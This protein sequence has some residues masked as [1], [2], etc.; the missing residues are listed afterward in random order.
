M[1]L[2]P[3][4]VRRLTSDEG[5]ERR[6]VALHRHL[7]AEPVENGWHDVYV[8]GKGIDL[9]APTSLRR[10]LGVADDE[11][12]VKGFVE[13]PALALQ[14]VIAEVLTMIGSEDDEG[15]VVLAGALQLIDDASD[16][17]V[18]LAHQ[19]IVGGSGLEDGEVVNVRFPAVVVE[20]IRSAPMVL[21]HQGE[22]RVLSG[23]V[24]GGR[25][26]A[27]GGN[28]ARVVHL[29]IR[30]RRHE[31]RVW[32]LERKVEEPGAFAVDGEPVE[33]FAGG[34]G[35]FAL[36]GAVSRRR[37]GV[38][39]LLGARV[40]RDLFIGIR[41]ALEPL[42]SP[43]FKPS[44]PRGGVI[45]DLLE[46][47]KHPLVGLELRISRL[48]G[49]RVR[50]SAGVPYEY[51]IVARLARL[52]RHV[53]ESAIEGRAVKD[54]PVIEHVQPGQQRG[55]ARGAGSSLGV[56]LA[57]QHSIGGESVEVRSFDAGMADGAKGVSAPLVRGDEQD[58]PYG[59]LCHY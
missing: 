45:G 58:V 30:L 26:A 40:V 6:A 10:R 5:H 22:I 1:R 44:K 15:L 21:D 38:S 29:V 42:V 3:P 19:S 24:L 50:G 46:P 48:Q 35:S 11:G 41:G 20:Q 23:L 18:D 56:M 52:Q 8:L 57:K 13:I 31:G 37:I 43:P 4:V 14:V 28:I 34:E 39:V 32:T 49:P 25:R 54:D 51:R 7:Q 2:G 9:A 36:L 17:V 27:R 47:R 55:P 16:M 12:D 59:W 33:R 53:G